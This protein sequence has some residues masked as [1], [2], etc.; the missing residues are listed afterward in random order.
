MSYVV[1]SCESVHSVA[2]FTP[3]R[4]ALL[5]PTALPAAEGLLE[6][7]SEIVVA[8]ASNKQNVCFKRI[9]FHNTRVFFTLCVRVFLFLFV[10]GDVGARPSVVTVVFF[11]T[12]KKRQ[13]KHPMFSV[14]DLTLTGKP[15]QV[16]SKSFN[17]G[18]MRVTYIM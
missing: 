4:S 17:Q 8:G 16:G 9:F 15:C 13:V 10:L 6:L 2:S 7:L 12:A 3:S 1:V 18:S 11:G 5:N 14:W